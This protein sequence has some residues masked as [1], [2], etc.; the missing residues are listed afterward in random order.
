MRAADKQQRLRE[1][2]FP[3]VPGELEQLGVR[4]HKRL[5]NRLQLC[6]GASNRYSRLEPAHD[7]QPPIRAI[8]ERLIRIRR[9]LLLHGDGDEYVWRRTDLH[10]VESF[11]SHADNGQWNTVYSERLV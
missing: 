9:H 1:V 6:L 3:I 2:P 10:A 7:R 5:I 8:L 11:A 4:F